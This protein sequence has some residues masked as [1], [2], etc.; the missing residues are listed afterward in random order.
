MTYDF[1]ADIT[2]NA[3]RSQCDI[4]GGP[5]K[6][7]HSTFSQI[8]RKLLK[9]SKLFFAHIK[10]CMPNMLYSQEFINSFYSVAPSGE[11]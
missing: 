5:K 11:C 8:S 6:R 9:I 7:G 3:D 1:T 2:G 10:A 4:Q